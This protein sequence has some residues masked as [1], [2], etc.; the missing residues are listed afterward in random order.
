MID[1]L[2]KILGYNL[3]LRLI[4]P[5]DAEYVHGLRINPLYNTHL[6]AVTG[7][8]ADQRVWIEAYKT[9]EGEG[10]EYYYIIERLDGIACGV[11]RLYEIT[12][13][14]FTWGSW[15]LDHNKPAKAALES[16]LLSFGIGFERLGLKNVF[17]DAKRNN[18]HAIAFYR[19]LGAVETSV[20]DNN[21]YFEYERNLFM[22]DRDNHISI[23]Q[24]ANRENK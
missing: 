2:K 20:D 7:T 3:C 10:R 11:V 16:A 6:S 15:I 18:T 19:R 1:G 22:R 12:S 23:L 21:V 5:E 17:F 8:E 4:T 14:S 9:R 13:D 24:V